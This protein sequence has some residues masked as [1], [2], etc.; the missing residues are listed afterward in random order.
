VLITSAGNGSFPSAV[1][2][3]Y[4]NV[5]RA[6]SFAAA[7]LVLS[8]VIIEVGLNDG[9]STGVVVTLQLKLIASGESLT[10]A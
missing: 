8:T 10:V 5:S 4:N 7:A 9:T 2:S 1:P 3:P 6:D